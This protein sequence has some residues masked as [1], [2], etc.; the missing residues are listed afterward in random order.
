MEAGQKRDVSL[1]KRVRAM[2]FTG[3]R[4]ELLTLIPA[5][6]R[7]I[8]DIGCSAGDVGAALKTRQGQVRVT[9]IEID[10][11]MAEAAKT[12]LDQV[13]VGDIESLAVPFRD[14]QFD[15]IVFADVLEH[16]REPKKLLLR[17]KQWLSDDGLMIVSIPNI[18][19]LSILAQ[20]IFFDEWRYEKCGILDETH[21]RFYTRK[22]FK[23]LLQ[24][25]SLSIL[26]SGFILSIRGSKYLDV[27]TFGLLRRFLA[28][29]YIFVVKKA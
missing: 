18:G 9:G 8:L 29:Q 5:N 24:E 20:L 16:L 13:I 23:R 19:H 25:T 1:I 17:A 27:L 6:A 4:A 12:K 22:T 21:L 15:V 2:I 28:C 26:K 7:E 11:K 3:D 10:P 14:K